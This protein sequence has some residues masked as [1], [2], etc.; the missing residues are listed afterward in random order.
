ML[1]SIICVLYGHLICVLYGH[2]IGLEHVWDCDM[3]YIAQSVC[4][5]CDMCHIEHPSCVLCAI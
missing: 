5:N 4:C 2:N 3:C 1:Y